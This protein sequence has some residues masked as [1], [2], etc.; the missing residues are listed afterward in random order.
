M[1]RR[2][3]SLATRLAIVLAAQSCSW[4]PS[5]AP[6]SRSPGSRRRSTPVGKVAF[7]RRLAVPRS[8]R[9]TVDA[10]GRRVFDLTGAAGSTDFGGDEPRP[11]ASTATTS[12]PPCA[13]H[14]GE[15]VL[16]KFH[17]DLP[18][19]TTVHWHGMHL[20]AAMDGGRTR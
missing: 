17:N 3:R 18:E 13:A 1:P 15:Q 11:G 7:D 19:A 10:N 8:A 4:S 5:A 6:A 16:V 2:R 12:A 14:R 20:P 9:S